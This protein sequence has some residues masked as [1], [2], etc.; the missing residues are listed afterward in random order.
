VTE[1]QCL[2]ELILRIDDI[3]ISTRQLVN[4]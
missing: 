1:Y 2:Q 4:D 3:P